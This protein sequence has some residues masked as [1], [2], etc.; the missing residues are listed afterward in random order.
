MPIHEYECRACGLSFERLVRLP[1]APDPDEVLACPSCSSRDLQQLISGFSV[2][3]A[4]T[5]QTHLNQARKLGQKEQ[6]E[7]KHA[8]M[9]AILHHDD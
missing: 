3:S 4:G 2:S 5:R 6:Q 8:E 7:K 9:E 1:N